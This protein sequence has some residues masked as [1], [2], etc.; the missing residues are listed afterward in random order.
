[1]DKES[2]CWLP[3]PPISPGSCSLSSFPLSFSFSLFL[4][5]D[6]D[7]LFDFSSFL[8]SLLLLLRSRLLLRSFRSLLRLRSLLSLLLSL[9]SLLL[10]LS[11]LSLLLLLL[12]S[13][14][15]IRRGHLVWMKRYVTTSLKKC[16]Q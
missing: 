12:S 8:L 1:M 3:S 7:L 5:R 13:Q 15:H 2:T 14:V 4:S 16:Y 10:L 6:L 11:L 9:F